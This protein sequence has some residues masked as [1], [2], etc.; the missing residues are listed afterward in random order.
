VQLFALSGVQLAGLAASGAAALKILPLRTL[1]AGLSLGTPRARLGATLVAAQVAVSF[2]LVT[3]AGLFLDTLHNIENVPL[4]MDTNHIVTA[5]IDLGGAYQSGAAA[6]FF[7]RL[8]AGL[9][10]LPGVTGV[11][12]SDSL[13]PTGGGHARSFFDLRV[14]GR[15]PF[16]KGRGGLV[17]WN[18]VTPGYFKILSIPIIEG[19]GFL[20]G[21]Q[22][23]NSN[24]V[25]VSR[26]LA[27]RLVP[28]DSAVGKHVQ[29]SA[30]SGPWYT[31][32]GVAGDVKYL[33]ASGRV[34]RVDPA[35]YLP[36]PRITAASATA[37]VQRHA[38]FLVESPLK[39]A[40]VE[41]LVRSKLASL[42]PTLPAQ[43]ST[44]DARVEN[45]RVQPRFNAALISLFAAI[46]FVLAAIGIYGVLS[47]T[48]S[49][50]TREI[51]LRMALGAAPGNVLRLV[52]W[53]GVRLI[54]TGLVAGA[55]LA[56]SVAHLLEGLLYGVSPEDPV[57]AAIAAVLLLLAGLL[58]CYIPARRAMRVDPMVALRYE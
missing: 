30:P 29:L 23:P 1:L 58:A 51:G 7:E 19:R 28:Q 55:V 12:A 47:F 24:V 31:V 25:I 56:L 44:L 46:G 11:A 21:D 9:R 16:P 35:Y 36:W 34:G 33:N 18:V 26:K 3:G 45:L 43:I 39:A 54:V 53:R 38:F 14:E 15:P 57:I 41:R 37:P 49:S 42:D 10:I 2:V 6:E 27:A 13:P 4:G 40:A 50:R 20:P 22:D 5:E 17:G 48:V 32:V 8:E 52:L